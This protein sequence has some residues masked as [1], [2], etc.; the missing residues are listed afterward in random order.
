[1]LEPNRESTRTE[2]G[3]QK[4][5]NNVGSECA[6]LTPRLPA[7]HT[8]VHSARVNAAA[9]AAS[10]AGAGPHAQATQQASSAKGGGG[11]AGG[12]GGYT[13]GGHLGKAARKRCTVRKG[14]YEEERLTKDAGPSQ[15]QPPFASRPVRRAL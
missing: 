8:G 14:A 12:G 5:T 6:C 1:M 4:A 9:L 11:E 10:R 7:L 2:S 3:A 15:P 13:T